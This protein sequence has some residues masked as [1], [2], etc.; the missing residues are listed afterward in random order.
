[1]RVMVVHNYYQ[2]AGGEDY[3]VRDELELLRRHGDTVHTFFRHNDA[4]KQMSSLAV[5]KA[6]V[7]NGAIAA[8]LEAEVRRFRPD[9]VHFHNTFPLISPAAYAAARRAGA[10]VV[11]SLHNYRLTCVNAVLM[12]EGTTCEDC[13]GSAFAWKGVMRGCYRGS[14]CQSLGVAAMTTTHRVLGTWKRQVDAY[15]AMTRFQQAKLVQAGVPAE[16]LHLKPNFAP[17]LGP[18]EMHGPRGG[19]AMYL[20]RLSPEKG[21][22]VLLDAWRRLGGA[23]PL[24]IVGGGPMQAEVE[25]VAAAVPGITWLRGQSYEQVQTLMR[26]A[27]LLI[28]PSINFE[29]FPRV[30]VEA[31]SMGTPIVASRLGSM[32]ELI[33]AGV[34][35]EHFT[36]GDGADLAAVVTRLWADKPRLIPMR[37][38]I[39][40]K[41]VRELSDEVNY[42]M[43]S[44]IYAAAIERRA[45]RTPA[46]VV[47]LT[48]SANA[49][50][51]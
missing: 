6:T 9:V 15:I 38:A 34:T 1:M 33:E 44:G 30:I 19:Y 7:W 11:Q 14:R 3:V 17:D 23:V 42:R 50:A 31:A 41:F 49:A 20:G 47:P 51:A 13:V 40:A 37:Q 8:E 5:A 2:Q 43:L 45:G 46:E 25:A 35:G 21:V 28:V 24:K 10:A 32:G 4:I 18:G 39:R 26:E 16:K 48:V 29:G 36:A 22:G 27:E 12:R